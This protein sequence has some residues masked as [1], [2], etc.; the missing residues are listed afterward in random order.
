MR[1][2]ASIQVVW[3]VAPIEGA[4]SIELVRVL[5]WQCAASKGEFHSGDK[6]VY[7][8]VDSFL[9]MEPRYEFLAKTSFRDN[10]DNGQGYRIKTMKFRGQVSQGLALGLPKFPEV[11]PSLPAGADLTELLNVKQWFI[12]EV[13]TGAGLVL[14]KRPAGVPMSDETRIQSEP[15]RL[16]LL[17]GK[18][19][20]ITTKMDGT[21]CYNY[22]INGKFGVCSRN[23]EMGLLDGESLYWHPEKRYLIKDRLASLGANLSIQG[24][25]CGPGIQKNPLRLNSFDYFVYDVRVVDQDRYMNFPELK[26][27]CDKLGLKMVP[28]EETGDSF[29]RTMEE[30]LIKA[31][32]KYPNGGADKEGIVVR[33]TAVNTPRLSFKV[34]NNVALAKEK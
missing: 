8:E 22:F 25:L 1:K 19:Y 7:F 28:V 2:L 29:S 27:F 32:G 20:Y 10:A 14:G 26:A 3:N 30:L 34:L 17:A 31:Q 4:D 18:P 11:D 13:P 33:S 12:N 24:E 23:N 6:A 21:A 15:E 9:P 16:T 5:G